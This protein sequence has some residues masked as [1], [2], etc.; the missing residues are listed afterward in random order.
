MNNSITRTGLRLIA[1]A[2][3]IP[4]A[5][6]WTGKYLLRG[7]MPATVASARI[8]GTVIAT[9]WKATDF[10]QLRRHAHLVA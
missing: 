7:N 8:L 1:T 6:R 9:P 10:N 5:I 4:A 2:W 3:N